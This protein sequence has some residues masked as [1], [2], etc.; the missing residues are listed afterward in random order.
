[1]FTVPLLGLIPAL[2][3]DPA[4]HHPSG[5]H[6]KKVVELGGN[7]DIIQIPALKVKNPPAAPAV[8]VMVRFAIEIVA[9]HSAQALHD[10]GQADGR[11]RLQ[12]AVDGVVGDVGMLFPN[13]LVQNIRG[14]V[15]AAFDQFAVYGD[16]LGRDP[17]AALS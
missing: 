2:P 5:G 3:A 7:V 10:F 16:T 15:V 14:G 12:S 17:E 9:P 6:D 1:M 11:E 8:E 13:L 4:Q